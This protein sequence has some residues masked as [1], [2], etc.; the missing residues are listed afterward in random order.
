MSKFSADIVF[1]IFVFWNVSCY[2]EDRILAGKNA[3]FEKRFPGE[4]QSRT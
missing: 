1:S 2:M 3:G 4:Y